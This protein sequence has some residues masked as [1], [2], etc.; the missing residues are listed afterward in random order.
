LIIGADRP[1]DHRRDFL[2]DFEDVAPRFEDQRGVG[3]DAVHHPE[4][5]QFSDLIGVCGIDE[6][7][8][9][10]GLSG[11]LDMAAG[12]GGSGCLPPGF[13]A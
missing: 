6:E 9:G 3:G 7:F 8:H 1:F 2:R 13:T 5:V 4:V 11:G 12:C 10:A